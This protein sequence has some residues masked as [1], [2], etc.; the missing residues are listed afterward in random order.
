MGKTSTS[1]LTHWSLAKA[2]ESTQTGI[3]QSIVTFRLAAAAPY[4]VTLAIVG[5]CSTIRA[6]RFQ[7][8]VID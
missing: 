7:A 5:I 6:L 2:V 1:L 4:G 3:S 8:I